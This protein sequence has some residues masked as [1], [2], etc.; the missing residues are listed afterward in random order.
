MN[1]RKN[2]TGAWQ[3]LQPN[4]RGLEERARQGE[5]RPPSLSHQVSIQR[6]G[7]LGTIMGRL[8]NSRGIGFT[9]A[10]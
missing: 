10:G 2:G 5:V 9:Q 4:G 8:A 1:C 7:A 6:I 3:S